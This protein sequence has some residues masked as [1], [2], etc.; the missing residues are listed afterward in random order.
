[1]CY[2]L[3]W[4]D[5]GRIPFEP[6]GQSRVCLSCI[7]RGKRHEV[8]NIAKTGRVTRSGRIFALE[9]LWNRDPPSTR[10]EKAVEAPKKIVT[11]E[12]VHEF[13]KMIHHSKYEILDQLHKTP[14]RVSFLSLLINSEGHHE[15]LLKVLSDAHGVINNISAIHHLSFSKDEVLAEGRSHN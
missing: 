13:L 11:E 5:G 10:K 3:G 7:H 4:L 14:A 8:S 12:E 2:G 6:A 15:H 1:M 9:G